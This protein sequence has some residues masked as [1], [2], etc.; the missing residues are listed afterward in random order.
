MDEVIE[1]SCL[2]AGVLAVVR[3]REQLLG[4]IVQIGSNQVPQGVEHENRGRGTPPLA[5]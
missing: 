1:V 5:R 2:Q 4:R 3:E